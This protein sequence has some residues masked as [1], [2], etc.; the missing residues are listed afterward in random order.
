MSVNR[1]V[2]EPP[3]LSFSFLLIIYVADPP[4]LRSVQQFVIL[5]DPCIAE[6]PAHGSL[7]YP[8]FANAVRRFVY[9]ERQV[10]VLLSEG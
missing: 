6:P 4:A 7:Y 2:A 9:M 8:A 1:F 5:P 10:P 3:A